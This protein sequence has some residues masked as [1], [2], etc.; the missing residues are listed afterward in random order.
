MADNE[1]PVTPAGTA[2][3]VGDVAVSG[4]RCWVFTDLAARGGC[5]A[6]LPL[7]VGAG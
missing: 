1:L 2:H 6:S 3:P 4:W 7:I 5:S